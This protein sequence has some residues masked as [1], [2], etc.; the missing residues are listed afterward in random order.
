[1]RILLTC[2]LASACSLGPRARTYPLAQTPAG[3][4]ATVAHGNS[5][6][7]AEVLAVSDSGLLL[8]WNDRVVLA[9][10]SAGT[11]IKLSDPDY[12]IRGQA[13][14]GQVRER[15]RLVTRYPAGVSPA[16]L[17]NLLAAYHQDSLRVLVP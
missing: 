3:V 16:L 6:F 11:T 13:P 12:T 1:M 4:T 5:T 9:R 2:L 14:T 10:Y 7:S 15:I 17:A 8:V